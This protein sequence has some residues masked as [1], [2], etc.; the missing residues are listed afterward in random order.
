MA[1]HPN[2]QI[3]ESK[4][5]RPRVRSGIVSRAA[6]VDRLPAVEM[7]GRQDLG[8]SSLTTAEL[9]LRHE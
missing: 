8:G 4:L 9:R 2:P 6:L 1:A 5:R 3:L 7:I